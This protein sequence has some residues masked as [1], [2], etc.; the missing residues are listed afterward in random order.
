M[1]RELGGDP[2]WRRRAIAVL[3]ELL[4]HLLIRLRRLL[5]E[6]LDV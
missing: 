1:E 2:V 3:L 6:H 4:G 5:R